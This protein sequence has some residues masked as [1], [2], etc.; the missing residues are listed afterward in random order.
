MGSVKR[1]NVALRT[2]LEGVDIPQPDSDK[3]PFIEL[4]NTFSNSFIDDSN[5]VECEDIANE[6]DYVVAAP[7]KQLKLGGKDALQKLPPGK[8]ERGKVKNLPVYHHPSSNKSKN[9]SIVHMKNR[10]SG[11]Y[12]DLLQPDLISL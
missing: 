6:D 12:P 3:K 8:K 2:L 5:E 1:K 10:P 11:L 9:Y 4:N 7:M